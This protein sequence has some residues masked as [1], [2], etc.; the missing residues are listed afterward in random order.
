MLTQ[1][2]QPF[3]NPRVHFLCSSFVTFSA[4]GD[5]TSSRAPLEMHVWIPQWHYCWSRSRDAEH[6]TLSMTVPHCEELLYPK[7]HWHPANR[8]Q[9]RSSKWCSPN[10]WKRKCLVGR[11]TVPL[12]FRSCLF[13]DEMLATYALSLPCCSYPGLS[14]MQFL[15]TTLGGEVSYGK[16]YGGSVSQ[17]S[18]ASRILGV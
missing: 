13:S 8:Q 3:S 9:W 6:L 4:R 1:W 18:P 5:T 15:K 11:G 16:L 12:L 14:W 7:R 2:H 17:C 10:G